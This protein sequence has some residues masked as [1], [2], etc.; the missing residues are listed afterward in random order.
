MEFRPRDQ[1]AVSTC[2]CQQSSTQFNCSMTL[3]HLLPTSVAAFGILCCLNSTARAEREADR[4]ALSS[5]RTNYMDAVNSG[6]L[7]KF[8]PHLSKGVTG[9]MVTGEEVKG[10]EGLQSYWKK[11][12]D[13]IGPGGSYQVTVNADKT[14]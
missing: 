7:S 8:T 13:L 6:D 3:K 11:I 14:D 1:N 4:A 10:L 2:H 5:I 9:V 12:Q